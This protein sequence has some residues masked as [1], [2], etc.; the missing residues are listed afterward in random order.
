MI[1]RRLCWFRATSR[2]PDAIG[3]I[4]GILVLAALI[5]TAIP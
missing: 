3:I 5:A 2:L 4:A 1:Q